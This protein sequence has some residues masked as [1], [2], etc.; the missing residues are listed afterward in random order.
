[1]QK[2]RQFLE[3]L[4]TK[5]IIT[6]IAVFGFI[7][8][9]NSLFNGFVWDD[10][11]QIVNNTIIHS[12]G[13]LSYIFSGATFN[14]GGAAT[15]SGWFFRPFITLWF[16]LGY[17]FFKDNA[18]G[19]HLA[20][21]I[22]HLFNS[23]LVYF[24]LD[25]ITQKS[26]SSYRKTLNLFLSIIFATHPGISE[27]VNYIS[28]VSELAYTT[29]LL[30]AVYLASKKP[31]INFFWIGTIL[32]TGALY[33]ESALATFPIFA[34]FGLLYQKASFK[35]YSLT[36]LISGIIYFITRLLI[37]RTPIRHPEFSPISEATLSERIMTIP[38]EIFDYLRLTFYPMRL[39]IS[40][41]Y[42]VKAISEPR[43]VLG[44]LATMIFLS[45]LFFRYAKTKSKSIIFGFSWLVISFSIISNV[46]PLD[47]TI[48]ERWYY[49]PIIG[50]IIILSEFL[51]SQTVNKKSFTPF[52]VIS[53]IYLVFF[54]IRT[55]AR[56]LNWHNGLSLYS[57]DIK[58]TGDSF[59]LENNL[60]VELYRDGQ[61]D[62]AAK[63]FLR[64]IELQ[65]KWHFAYNNIGAYYQGKGDYDK[66]ISYYK[67]T[68]E[69]SDYHLSHQNLAAAYYLQGNLEEA[70]NSAEQSLQK[71]PNNPR[72][73][74]ILAVAKLD[75]GQYNEALLAAQRAHL[76]SPSQETYNILTSIQQKI[77][78]SK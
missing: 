13:N 3:S 69:V 34:L 31:K 17:A 48:A 33:K 21:L 56:N 24:L 71:L 22:L 68:L 18:F 36:A 7:V 57:H 26:Q 75:L 15:L 6:S 46:I 23:I 77:S 29:T 59:D 53:I 45:F 55:F 20:Q 62:Q 67:Q 63:H 2:L 49:F 28:A 60:G 37:V 78:I 10:E 8:Y 41:H 42:V 5:Q 38:A 43:F 50:V 30:V 51:H 9:F 27:A 40:Q 58:S 14:T 35:K 54:S 12:L 47:M 1:M 65:P 25:L 76:L 44:V 19:Y 11:E 70:V 32:F 39:A 4:S 73:W 64:S 61:H 16:M 66:A 52:F 74:I 72:L